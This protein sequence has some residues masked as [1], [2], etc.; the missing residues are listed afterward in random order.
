MWWSGRCPFGG[1]YDDKRATELPWDKAHPNEP[2][3]KAWTDWKNDQKHWCRGGASY[4][5][6]HCEHYIQY[7]EKDTTVRTCLGCNITQFQDGYI[8]CSLIEHVGCEECCKKY[9]NS[10][11]NEERK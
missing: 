11:D 6:E 8:S 10:L 2:P 3:R 5:T 9:N 4:A 1:C 7:Q